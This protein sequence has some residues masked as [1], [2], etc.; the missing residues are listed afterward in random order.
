MFVWGVA[1]APKAILMAACGRNGFSSGR[2][3]TGSVLPGKAWEAE[4]MCAS[5]LRQCQKT[6]SFIKNEIYMAQGLFP[7]NEHFY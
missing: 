5:G 4:G 7:P 6:S 3:V 1:K 2:R